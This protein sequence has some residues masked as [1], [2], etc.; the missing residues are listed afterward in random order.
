MRRSAHGPFVPDSDYQLAIS[1][2]KKTPANGCHDVKRGSPASSPSAP[3]TVDSQTNTPQIRG[4]SGS[5]GIPVAPQASAV[6]IGGLCDLD[7]GSGIRSS[8]M[9][10]AQSAPATQSIRGIVQSLEP[11]FLWAGITALVARRRRRD[12]PVDPAIDHCRRPERVYT[13][14]CAFRLTS[15]HTS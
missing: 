10:L 15:S 3:Q 8:R 9:G 5:E 4:A 7:C 12:R 1:V 11:F 14:T 2:S 6:F 13:G